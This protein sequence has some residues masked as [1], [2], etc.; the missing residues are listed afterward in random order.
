[1][2][3]PKVNLLDFEAP[4][5]ASR[6]KKRSVRR[7]FAMGAVGIVFLSSFAYGRLTYSG[8]TAIGLERLKEMPIIYQVS[9]LMSSPDRL[10]AG[11]AED[12][13]NILLLGMGGEGHDGANLTDTIIV[14]SL[15]PSDHQVAMLSVPR[16]LLVPV[17]NAGWRKINSANA[18]GEAK[19]KGNGG[20]TS[21]AVMESLLGLSLPYY[22]RIDFNGFKDIVDSVDGVDIYVDNSFKDYTYPTADYKIQTVAFTKGWHHMDGETALEYTRSRHG[23]NGEGSDFARSRRQQKVIMAL[24]EKV[25]SASMLKNP[26]SIANALAALRAN[27]TTNLQ[28]GEILRLAKIGQQVDQTNIMHKVL[29]DGPGSPLVSGNYGGAYVLMPR[30]NDWGAVRDVATNLFSVAE[31]SDLQDGEPKPADLAGTV[32]AR[33]G[34]TKQSQQ[35]GSTDATTPASPAR[36]EI[37]N[38]TGV[39]GGARLVSQAVAKAGFTVAK[40]GNADRF[41]YTTTTVYDLTGGQRK[42]DLAKLKETATATRTVRGL[43]KGGASSDLDFVV[44]IGSN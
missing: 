4:T 17:P 8:T 16:D 5:Q 22:I 18:F 21:R 36:V 1:M 14:A 29:D 42:T 13:I 10:L 33:S 2:P 15:R 28:I 37:R 34:A 25:L 27:V 11:E 23:T 41:N 40:I 3:S 20:E 38:G 6:D 9:H 39:A 44:I 31:P 26:A 12:R 32:I 43:P 7:F 30:N 19:N 35:D 24:R